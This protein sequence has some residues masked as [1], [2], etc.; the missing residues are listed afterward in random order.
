MALASAPR[1]SHRIA[2]GPRG[3]RSRLKWLVADHL[4]RSPMLPP[5][6]GFERLTAREKEVLQLLAQGRRNDEIARTHFLSETTVKMHVTR[7]LVKL[8]ARYRVHP[9]VLAQRSGLV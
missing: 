1:A 7:T 8:G 4:D 6:P 2:H 5:P 3:L 9:V